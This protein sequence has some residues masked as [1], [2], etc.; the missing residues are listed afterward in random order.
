MQVAL[1]EHD[2]ITI[3]NSTNKKTE[4]KRSSQS[5]SILL[6]NPRS[7]S[8]RNT[9]R[10]MCCSR[11]TLIVNTYT[12]FMNPRFCAG[13]LRMRRCLCVTHE[14]PG[15]GADQGSGSFI[16]CPQFFMVVSQEAKHKALQCGKS[17][18]LT[19]NVESRGFLVVVHPHLYRCDAQSSSKKAT[20]DLV[21]CSVSCGGDNERSDKVVYLWR[22]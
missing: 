18:E 10:R 11:H 1:F 5:P 15:I 19:R 4:W 9:P 17:F 6:L 14:A 21:L 8:R 16:F 13:T 20:L 3:L 7:N 22:R 2:I 12:F